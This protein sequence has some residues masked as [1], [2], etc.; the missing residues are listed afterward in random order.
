M[1]TAPITF[2]KIIFRVPY[3]STIGYHHD[4]LAKYP[5]YSHKWTSTIS[6]GVE[7]FVIMASEQMSKYGYNV[8]G[9][10]DL[11]FGTDDSSSA[12][13]LIGGTI[14]D[15]GYN[16]FAPLAG[17]YSECGMTIEWQVFDVLENK[18]VYKTSE[19]GYAEQSSQ[20]GFPIQEAF[21]QSVNQLMSKAAFANLFMSLE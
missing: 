9:A 19:R 17:G 6:E 10:S 2:T 16:T 20:K 15:I 7:D 5:Q 8:V 13:F 21:V 14:T 4:G 1:K 11:L 18:V 12:E 3:G